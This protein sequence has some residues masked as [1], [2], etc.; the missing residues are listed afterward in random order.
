MKASTIAFGVALAAAFSTTSLAQEAGQVA[1]PEVQEN[2]TGDV[3]GQIAPG[4]EGAPGGPGAAFVTT[5]TYRSHQIAAGASA[6]NLEGNACPAT[7][8][9]LSGA[10]HPFYN[11]RVVIINQFPN[12]AGNTWRCGFKNNT[13]GTV[14]VYIYTLCGK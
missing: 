14:T 4:A 12:I 2:S 3:P 9:M 11:D 13:T 8:K 6:G 1:P 10:C 5:L 7:Y